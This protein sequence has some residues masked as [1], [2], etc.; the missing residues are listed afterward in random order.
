MPR[1][2][3]VTP[4]GPDHPVYPSAAGSR[5]LP[6]M[7]RVPASAPR[8]GQ[9]SSGAEPAPPAQDVVT[10]D[11][12]WAGRAELPSGLPTAGPP[13]PRPTEGRRSHRDRA[14]RD[15]GGGLSARGP[16]CELQTGYPQ[17]WSAP[18]PAGRRLRTKLGGRERGRREVPEASMWGGRGRGQGR[19]GWGGRH[20][21]GSG[22]RW[23]AW[24]LPRGTGP[25]ARC[26]A[27][28]PRQAVAGP[29]RAAGPRGVFQ[30]EIY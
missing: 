18:T 8:P 16:R 30:G 1:H 23:T 3:P 20:R 10:P 5:G 27:G 11:R 7:G 24:C 19:E 6:G 9:D 29:R 26:R 13:S 4:R 21:G 22:P 15:G 2:L 17:P 25:R 12:P 14:G 28:R